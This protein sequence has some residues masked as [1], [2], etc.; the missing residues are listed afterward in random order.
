MK[1]ELYQTYH[2]TTS[3]NETRALRTSLKSSLFDKSNS[4]FYSIMSEIA[5][6]FNVNL[7]SRNRLKDD[8]IY[9]SFIVTIFFSTARKETK[10]V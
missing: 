7:N 5:T 9:S 4:C 8:K 6:Y 3:V 1:L 10:I 2:I